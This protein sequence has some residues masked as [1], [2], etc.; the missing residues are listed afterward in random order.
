MN[1]SSDS[2]ME[3]D[4]KSVHEDFQVLIKELNMDSL[5]GDKAWK[6]YT[7]IKQK[8]TL[9]VRLLKIIVCGNDL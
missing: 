5:T 3:S 7:E 8:F 2:S 6:D 4:L 9:E 1:M